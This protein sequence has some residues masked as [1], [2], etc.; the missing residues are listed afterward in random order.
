M[1]GINYL[2][3]P[4]SFAL[5]SATLAVKIRLNRHVCQLTHTLY[6]FV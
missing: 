1:V 4:A 5:L 2:E 3:T 6:T